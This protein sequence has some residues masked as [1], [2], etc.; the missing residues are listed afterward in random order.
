MNQVRKGRE[1][2]KLVAEIEQAFAGSTAIIKRNDRIPDKETGTLREI[3]ISIRARVGSMDLLTIVECRNRNQ[4]ADARWI[5]ELDGK[6]TSVG[7]N[8]VVA[9]SSS[10]FTDE[11]ITKANNRNIE[12][13]TLKK[14]KQRQIREWIDA[15]PISVYHAQWKHIS[16]KIVFS[17]SAA[18]AQ[19]KFEGFQWFDEEGHPLRLFKRES[20][21]TLMNVVEL[22]RWVYWLVY[23]LDPEEGIGEAP[24]E[25]WVETEFNPGDLTMQGIGWKHEVSGV[26]LGF[27]IGIF[28]IKLHSIERYSSADTDIAHKVVWGND[29]NVNGQIMPLSI[30]ATISNSQANP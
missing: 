2:E 19:S 29:I 16:G 5:E 15:H 18:D 1:F 10:G 24:V 20:D 30:D 13:R 25:R 21:G 28:P 11:A 17:D 22:Y 23:G 14:L 4:K 9:V 26:Q 7:A 3:D 6:R 12:T 27:E 8:K